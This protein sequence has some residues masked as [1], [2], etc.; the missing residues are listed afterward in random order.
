MSVYKVLIIGKKSY[1]GKHIYEWLSRDSDFAVDTISVRDDDWKM[2]SYH[3]YDT[4]INV[5]GIAHVKI[6][7]NLSALFYKVNTELA[8][9]ICKEAKKNKCVQYIY[10][11]SMNV[12]GDT[13]QMIDSL[14]RPSPKNFYGDSKLQADIRIQQLGDEDFK[15]VS[16]RPP[17]VYG[18]ECKGNFPKL[19]KL[20]QI[21][22]I[23][24][25]YSNVRSVL[26]IDNLCELV[27][28]LI[29]DR[30]SGIVH[31]QNREKVST[32][33][34]MKFISEKYGRHIWMTRIFNPAI[35]LLVNKVHLVNRMFADDHY[36]L[37][38]SHIYDFKYCVYSTE[39][40]IKRS[41]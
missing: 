10:M 27:R 36:S 8:V 16:I 2:I 18:K 17:V 40:S 15:V 38:L 7:R 14:M 39:E 28:L 33:Q 22:P 34:M 20:G 24:P 32:T 41:I 19:V 4:I 25:D 5:S 35:R 6:K 21:T 12:Y 3:D 1:I 37:E 29:I 11:S 9:N 30:Y 31:P 23:F 26:Y 13:S